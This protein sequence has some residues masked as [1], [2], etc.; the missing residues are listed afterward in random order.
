MCVYVALM[1]WIGFVLA[2]I[3]I[4]CIILAYCREKKPFIYIFT[5]LASIGIFF[6]FRR[7]FH[8]SLPESP[9][10]FLPF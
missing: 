10:S 1:I 5:I 9:I 6:L 8:I 3:I 7:I 2:S 4:F